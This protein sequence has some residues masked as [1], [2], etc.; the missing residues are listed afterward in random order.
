MRI[1]TFLSSGAEWAVTF[2]AAALLGCAIVSI[3]P[4]MADKRDDAQHMLGLADV[5]A[6]IVWDAQVASGLEQAVGPKYLDR[7]LL[8]MVAGRSNLE[9]PKG[10][11]YLEKRSVEL[12]IYNRF[13][14]A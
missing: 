1:A 12:H 6:V 7:C 2:Y 4:A 5:S 3:N 8:R 14:I 10:W 9:L 13:V 11:V